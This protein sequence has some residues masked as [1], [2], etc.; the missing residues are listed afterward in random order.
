V[1]V[2]STTAAKAELWKRHRATTKI[3]ITNTNACVWTCVYMSEW[4]CLCMLT[5]PVATW[6][7][8]YPCMCVRVCVYVVCWQQAGNY[9]QAIGQ[10][11]WRFVYPGKGL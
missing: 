2:A 9:G 8:V 5:F 1:G 10:N 3:T 11:C 7:C 4:M 6:S